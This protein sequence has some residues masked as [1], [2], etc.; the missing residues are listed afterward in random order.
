MKTI[1]RPGRFRCDLNAHL[2]FAGQT[3]LNVRVLDLSEQGAFVA[4]NEELHYDLRGE[5]TLSLPGGGPFQVKVRVV[6]LGASL[7][8]VPHRTVD[9]ITV[10]RQGAAVAFEGFPADEVGRLK[11]FLESLDER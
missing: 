5:L 8:E 2:S 7:E 6:R 4:T 1:A 10:S 9:N 11:G 3:P